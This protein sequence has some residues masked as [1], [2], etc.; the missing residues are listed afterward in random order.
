MK[1]LKLDVIPM[2]D[3]PDPPLGFRGSKFD[4]LY[5][6]IKKLGYA[7]KDAVRVSGL[8]RKRM[9]Y[10]RARLQAMAKRE[11]LR[12]LSSRNQDSTVAFFWAI[13]Q[14]KDV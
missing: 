13:K 10:M 4:G 9:I 3:V 7:E 6:E 5:A 12:M 2:K 8:D 1:E 14:K 11:G